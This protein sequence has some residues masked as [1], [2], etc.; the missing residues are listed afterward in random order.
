VARVPQ[1]DGEVSEHRPIEIYP[2]LGEDRGTNAADDE[3]Q[4]TMNAVRR[5]DKEES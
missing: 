5:L 2:V 4:M 1:A 3:R